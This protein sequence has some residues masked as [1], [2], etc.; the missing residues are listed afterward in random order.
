[1]LI[2]WITGLTAS[3]KT[4]LGKLLEEKLILLGC[5]SVLR[6]DGDELRS[7]RSFNNSHSI[8][9]RWFNLKLIV[10]IVLEEKKNYKIIIVSTVSHLVAMRAYAR[11][12]V[13]NFHEIYLRC[14]PEICANRDYKNL[15]HKAKNNLL[16]ND[17]IFPGVTEPYQLTDNP[18]LVLDT[19]KESIDQSCNKLISYCKTI[20]EILDKS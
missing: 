1:M 6:V 13:E 15:Y 7:R 4:S 3:G 11:A 9:A 14:K 16:E 20:N 12:R 18:E 17:D 10:E 19:G 8:K 5:K 2:I